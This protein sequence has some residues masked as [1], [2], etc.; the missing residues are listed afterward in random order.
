[1]IQLT[2]ISPLPK[3]SRAAAAVRLSRRNCGALSTAKWGSR[4]A[5]ASHAGS[6]SVDLLPAGL[7][8]LRLLPEN[9][10]HLVPPAGGLVHHLQAV[11]SKRSKSFNRLRALAA[12]GQAGRTWRIPGA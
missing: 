8:T 9:H 6:G 2:R 5:N 3:N 11:D 1:S 12:D 10:E 7:G 4:E